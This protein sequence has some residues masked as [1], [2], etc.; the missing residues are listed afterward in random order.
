MC[1]V[2]CHMM[3]CDLWRHPVMLIWYYILHIFDQEECL[4]LPPLLRRRVVMS[5]P[6]DVQAEYQSII[7]KYKAQSQSQ[8]GGYRGREQEGAAGNSGLEM[9]SA[10]RK[11]SSAAKVG[12]VL[13]LSVLQYYIF[14]SLDR[15]G[16]HPII[17]KLFAF[18]SC[19]SISLLLCDFFSRLITQRTL[20]VS[21]WA[22]IAQLRWWSLFGIE[23]RH[24][25]WR[26]LCKH[27]P[28]SHM[29]Q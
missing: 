19:C 12:Q 20:F 22:R 9:V 7:Q 3:W 4:D 26:R 29:K 10:L 17:F 21:Y 15:R 8:Q 18:L 14:F 23:T 28:R 16:L 25:C 6:K 13:C 24:G 1:V 2:W 11:L 5:V 27:H